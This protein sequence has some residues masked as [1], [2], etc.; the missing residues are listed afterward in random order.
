MSFM[1]AENTR[2]YIVTACA[3]LFVTCLL[4]GLL[5][6]NVQEWAKATGQDQY[7]VRYAGVFVS[8]LADLTQSTAFLAIAWSFIGGASFL[9]IDYALRRRTK[10]MGITLL[11]VA[12]FVAAFGL[13]ILLN[14]NADAVDAAGNSTISAPIIVLKTQPSIVQQPPGQ[15]KPSETVL[16]PDAENKYAARYIKTLALLNSVKDERAKLEKSGNQINVSYLP[17]AGGISNSRVRN[18]G[19]A[20]WH[21]SI[22][23]LKSISADAYENRSFEIEVPELSNP[24]LKAPDED[25][26]IPPNDPMILNEYHVF[27][28]TNLNALK[29]ADNLIETLQKEQGQLTEAIR[30]MPSISQLVR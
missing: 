27:Y 10:K 24:Y 28:F 6:A 19:K 29:L 13:W 9:W 26:V 30:K 22:S 4:G 8:K 18:F 12:V 2:R 25:K 1:T 15:T 5:Q 7:L 23:K 21:E 20:A 16:L 14:P 11:V 17:L 3:F